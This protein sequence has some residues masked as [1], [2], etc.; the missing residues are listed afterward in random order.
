MAD[1]DTDTPDVQQPAG[2]PEGQ[3]IEEYARRALSLV[4]NKSVR[5]GPDGVPREW[6][7]VIYVWESGG[8]DHRAGELGATVN[9]GYA[10]V[11]VDVHAWDLNCGCPPGTRPVAWYHTHPVDDFVAHGGD[12]FSAQSREF[13]G[14]DKLI[15]DSLLLPGY[16][17]T[18]DGGF[19]R[20]DPP[21]QAI[22]DG[23]PYF[24]KGKPVVDGDKK[25]HY[26]MLKAKVVPLS[27]KQHMPTIKM[28]PLR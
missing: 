9:E 13:I 20:Y 14:G 16:V 19:W 3:R 17:A 7:G 10:M 8:R 23:K 4:L 15:S 18:R 5:G 6:G 12:R 27:I 28:P 1:P 22:V 26:G 24:Y 25:G 2:T 21:P 11:N